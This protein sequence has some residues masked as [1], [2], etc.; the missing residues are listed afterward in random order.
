MSKYRAFIDE[1]R[2]HDGKLVLTHTEPFHTL[3]EAYRWL[4]KMENDLN[5]NPHKFYQ[6]SRII[7]IT[8]DKNNEQ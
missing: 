4:K 7:L 6:N 3:K 8:E 1:G 2:I 5:N